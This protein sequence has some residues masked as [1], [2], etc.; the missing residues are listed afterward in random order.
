[1]ATDR[2]VRL[3]AG[4]TLAKAESLTGGG[5][6]GGGSGVEGAF[7]GGSFADQFHLSNNRGTASTDQRQRLVLSWIAEPNPVGRSHGILSALLDD[8][9]FD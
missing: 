4:Y 2:T 7:G 1:M 8:W 9:R 3:S 6:D 5:A